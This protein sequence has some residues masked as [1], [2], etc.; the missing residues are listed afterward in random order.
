[1]A[2]SLKV[3]DYA[4]KVMPHF[5]VTQIPSGLLGLIV[6]AILS[7]AMSTISSGMNSSATVFSVDIYKRYF[8]PEI[9]DKQNLFVL[10]T[11]T[12][13]FGLLGMGTGIAIIGAKSLLDVWWKLSGIF[14]GGVLGLFLLGIVSRTSKNAEAL[15]ATIIGAVVI[16]WMTFS[17]FLP[18]KYSFLRS[19]IHESMIIVIGTMTIFMAGLLLTL[20]RKER[21]KA[22]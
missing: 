19:P 3:S 12:V 21:V 11:G 16:L 20:V 6:S 4:D 14:A 18:E 10:H 8:R 5:M 22:A 1:M 13:I 15:T 17:S 9:S 2:S 7:A